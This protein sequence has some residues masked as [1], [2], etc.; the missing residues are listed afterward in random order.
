MGITPTFTPAE[1]LSAAPVRLEGFKRQL[2]VLRASVGRSVNA[3]T[4]DAALERSAG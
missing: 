4:E 2:V 1:E 3:P